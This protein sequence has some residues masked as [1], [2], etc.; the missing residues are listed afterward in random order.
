MRVAD[1]VGKDMNI[2]AEEIR[3]THGTYST[4][5]CGCYQ[6]T[7]ISNRSFMERSKSNI[8]DVSMMICYL[9]IELQQNVAKT[10]PF[11]VIFSTESLESS[12]DQTKQRLFKALAFVRALC[13]RKLQLMELHIIHLIERLEEEWTDVMPMER[14]PIATGFLHLAQVEVVWDS[15]MCKMRGMRRKESSSGPLQILLNHT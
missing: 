4:L 7:Q 5:R 1:Y 11:A 10:Y 6:T 3:I 9:L 8:T 2:E 13:K 15:V 14:S 12:K